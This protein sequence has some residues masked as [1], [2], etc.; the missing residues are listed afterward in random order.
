MGT[1]LSE[2]LQIARQTAGLSQTRLA[3]SIGMD[4]GMVSNVDRGLKSTSFE[5]V[6]AWLTAC[7]MQLVVV[8][9]DVAVPAEVAMLAPDL[10]EL[11]LKLAR[12]LPEMPIEARELLADQVE[13]WQRRYRKP[14]ATDGAPGSAKVAVR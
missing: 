8:P 12:V 11:L 14:A 13:S 5:N 6:D 3:D 9:A 7:N 2:Q 4:R 10:R 1:K